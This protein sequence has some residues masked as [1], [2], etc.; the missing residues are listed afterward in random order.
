MSWGGSPNCATCSK[1]VYHAEQVMGPGR[2]IYHK[3][4]LKCRQCGKRLDPGGLVE[5]DNEPFCTPCHRQLFGTRDLRHNNLY[6]SPS[7]TQSPPQSTTPSLPS[8]PTSPLSPP[9]PRPLPQPPT[10]FYTP[11]RLS[12]PPPASPTLREREDGTPITRPDFRSSRPISVPYAG[13]PKALD[14]RGLLRQGNSPRA[15]W[16][17]KP[18]VGEEVCWGCE[19]RVY[20]AEQVFAVGHKWHRG[21]LRCHS[22]KTTVDPSRVSDRDGVPYCNN[23]YAKEHGPGGI[24]GK[25]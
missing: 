25:R 20:A 21:C 3:Q 2:K 15:K 11:P 13:G 1:A 8:L 6:S 17:E 24:M 7:R 9:R 16:G 14:D 22:C 19:K 5:H 23:C 12:D 18:L 4:C 10:E